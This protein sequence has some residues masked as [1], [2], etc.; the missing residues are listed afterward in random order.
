MDE[1]YNEYDVG[2]PLAT[3]AEP[4]SFSYGEHV[5]NCA[6][7]DFALSSNERRTAPGFTMI[8]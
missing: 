4:F 1:F 3:S 5:E 6:G 7:I 2:D 8:C